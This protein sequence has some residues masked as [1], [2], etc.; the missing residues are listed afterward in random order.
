MEVS[1]VV[2]VYNHLALTRECLDS[3]EATVEGVEYEVIIV[4]DG[5]DEETAEGLRTLVLGCKRAKLVEN[6]TNQGF[7]HANNLGAIHARGE[8]L[9]LAN[10]DLKFRPG[11]LQPMLEGLRSD[12]KI[13]I[14]G[15][16]Q[17]SVATGKVDH[18]GVNFDP[19]GNAIHL[20]KRPRTI[21]GAPRY[22]EFKAVTGA[23]CAIRR[24]LYEE[25][26]GFDEAFVNGGEDVDLCFRITQLGHKI[27]VANR[28]VVDHHVS[29]TRREPNRE[30]EWN[31]RLLQ[32]RWGKELAS[33]A[34]ASWPKA[35]LRQVFHARHWKAIDWKLLKEALP[36]YLNLK[37][38]PAE[39]A[40][41]HAFCEQERNE[42]H[43]RSTLDGLTDEEIKREERERHSSPFRDQYSYKGLYAEDTEFL[44]VWIR[45]FA[46]IS[47]PR[48]A[49]V[50][51]LGI[52]GFSHDSCSG[53]DS[54]KI[55]LAIKINDAAI[56]A[57]Y[58]IA[59]GSFH[60]EF[61]NLPA[62]ASDKTELEIILLGVER[63]NAY[64]YL[65]RK[66][67]KASF[68]PK[69]LRSSFAKYR[70]QR[71]NKRLA[72]HGI[73]IN[74]EDVF[75][76]KKDPTNPLNTDYVIKH[77]RMGVNLVGWFKAELGIGES[78]RVAAKALQESQL[79]FSLVNLKVNCL[80]SQ[81][82]QTYANELSD[83]NPNPINIFHID[84][85]QSADID[86][87]HGLDFRKD[88]YN[89]AYW[90]WELPDFP[91]EWTKYMRYFNEIWA[92]SNFVRD[93]IAMKSPVPVLTV[94]H[95]ID[96]SIPD[97]DYRKELELPSD[98]F[99]FT[100]AY[101][102]NSYQERKN[103]KAAI[104]AFR[105]AFAGSDRANDVGLVLK[106]H[107]A[108]NNPKSYNGLRELLA[109]IPNCYLIDK[110]LS[111]E[112]TYGLMKACDSYISLHRSEG[113][114]LT[115]AE[116][117]LLGKPVVS[118]NWS[119][120]SEFVNARNG[121]PVNFKLIPLTQNHG[122]Y[123]VGQIWA[124]PDSV[125]AASYMYKLVSDSDY[126]NEL[127]IHAR[128]S[129]KELYSRERIASIYRKRLRAISLW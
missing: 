96:F 84:A 85:P 21:V 93:S 119:A 108:A 52:S 91:D 38:S 53:H 66:L 56:N 68:L 36:R 73:H 76:F 6:K 49:L 86:H 114:G 82:D 123:K 41:Y 22:T 40:L 39:P 117:M 118:T 18:A 112:M 8:I 32:N 121:C 45:E 16:I 58:P 60:L 83:S 27:L 43:W 12:A 104:E 63:T 20:R 34:A 69:L 4:N 57:S 87:H 42:R 3:I 50:S 47:I 7:A 100:F 33:L 102:L 115:V 116:S 1:F 71:L 65:G 29:A 127:G 110:T 103:P 70:E 54:G 13:G 77:S 81:G 126:A 75:D 62:R 101:D 30:D 2:P 5:C 25:A 26:G 19:K 44:G 107:S 48:G 79:P 94:P 72:I 98:K 95:C 23:C 109:G 99:L 11:W 67:A 55:G 17:Y 61:E 106:V 59:P 97:R 125:H 88:K 15:N 35:Y 105:Q 14:V 9:V 64:A 129:I 78:A 128:A 74:G 28:S 113:F 10:N 80:A 24:E 122:P 37:K 92:P 120:T 89:I 31:S 111:R 51:K 90:A 124:D 46:S